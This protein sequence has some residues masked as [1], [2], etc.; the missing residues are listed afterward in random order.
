VSY[1]SAPSEDSRDEGFVPDPLAQHI[2]GGVKAVRRSVGSL[3]VTLGAS[4]TSA[5]LAAGV[6][7]LLNQRALV[8]AYSIADRS[9]LIV[10]E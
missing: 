8:R 6:Q 2:E 10:L 5:D 1:D 3:L 4:I 7:S 9:E